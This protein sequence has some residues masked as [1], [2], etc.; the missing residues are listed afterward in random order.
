M[1]ILIIVLLEIKTINKNKLVTS[2]ISRLSWKLKI[3]LLKW[4][5]IQEIFLKQIHKINNNPKKV[6]II[7]V[8]YQKMMKRGEI[9]FLVAN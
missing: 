6:Q 5:K 2:K 9:L 8:I 3:S 7:F 1:I 4:D